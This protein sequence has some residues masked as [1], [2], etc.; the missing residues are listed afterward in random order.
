MF[1]MFPIARPT[2]RF[3]KVKIRARPHVSRYFWIRNFFSSDTATVHTHPVNSIANPDIFKSA[4]QSGKNK[5]ATSPTTC[6]R[7]NPDIFEFDDAANSSPVSYRTINQY[8]NRAN[9]APLSRVLWRMLWTHFIAEEPW[10]LQWI[11]TPSDACG[12]ANSI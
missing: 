10:V 4:L 11:W 6:G 3:Q 8:N 12:Q 9:L 7:V 1:C 5:S 2:H